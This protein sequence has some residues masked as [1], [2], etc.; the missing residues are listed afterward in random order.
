M[1]NKIIVFI[2]VLLIS[3]S[4]YN[5]EHTNAASGYQGW[6]VYRDGVQ[7]Q[8]Y[9][10]HAGLMYAANSSYT[11]AVIQNRGTGYVRTDT[12]SSFING[13]NFKGIYRPK[14][15]ATN[16][17]RDLFVAM[18]RNLASQYI[19][20]TVMQQMAVNGG[21]NG[22][23]GSYFEP[24]EITDMR[25]DG[26]VEYIY[27]WEGFRVWGSNSFWD[28]SVNNPNNLQEHMGFAVRPEVQKNYLTLVTTSSP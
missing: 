11:N 18:G 14:A 2:S 3:I 6:A 7:G 22:S 13:Q 9:I 25:C 4:L 16:V 12:W 15:T 10:W 23:L 8:S 1:K 21:P 28:I 24:A 20:Y 17:D 5:P 27:E 19:S 26:V